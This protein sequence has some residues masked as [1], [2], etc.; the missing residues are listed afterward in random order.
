VV[1]G[2]LAPAALPVAKIQTAA[3]AMIPVRRPASISAVSL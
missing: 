1:T 2:E 3:A